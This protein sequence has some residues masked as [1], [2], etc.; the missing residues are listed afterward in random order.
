MG[1]VIIE[2]DSLWMH[3]LQTYDT[4]IKKDGVRNEYER[5]GKDYRVKVYRMHEKHVAPSL[6]RV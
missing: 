5:K 6:P 3:K 1:S 4:S 2:L